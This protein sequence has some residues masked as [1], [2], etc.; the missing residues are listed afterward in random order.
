MSD[1]RVL[2]GSP[3]DLCERHLRGTFKKVDPSEK[4]S[5]LA[6]NAIYNKLEQKNVTAWIDLRNKAAHGKYSE[7]TVTQVELMYQGVLDF[8]LR[9]NL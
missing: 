6:S 3:L 1:R 7:Y 5:E 9:N 8:L 2:H 4:N